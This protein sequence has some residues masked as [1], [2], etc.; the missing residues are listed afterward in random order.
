M[1]KFV[2]EWFSEV[3]K[4]SDQKQI[5]KDKSAERWIPCKDGLPH[6]DRKVDILVYVN[7]GN[8]LESQFMEGS[9]NPHVGWN[10]RARGL[11]VA[12]R[13]R[14]PAVRELM[15]NLSNYLRIAV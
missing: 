3:T 12:W 6:S 10:M 2:K 7:D 4:S 15:E 13:D 8:K 11:V 14:D 1:I 5:D 9:F